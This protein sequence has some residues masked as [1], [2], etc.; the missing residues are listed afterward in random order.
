MDIEN[1]HKSNLNS[2][3]NF[4][5]EGKITLRVC[6]FNK[7]DTYN[8]EVSPEAF[9]E[10]I[11]EINKS[12]IEI[13]I[14]V[15][16]DHANYIIS[17]NINNLYKKEDGLYAEFKIDEEIK[18]S[19]PTF[20]Q[21]IIDLYNNQKL[22]A[23]MGAKNLDSTLKPNRFEKK[24]N[25]EYDLLKKLKLYHI[26]L[27]EDPIDKTAEVL[28]FKSFLTI[29]KYP[30]YLSETWDVNDANRKWREY[31]NSNEKPSD[32]YKNA[33]LY[34]ENDKKDL[35]GSYHFQIVD[36]I[37]GE[38]VINSRAI[39]SIRGYLAGARFGIKILNEAEKNKLANT[40]VILYRKM[41]VVREQQGLEPLEYDDIIVK[42]Q[43]INE[44]INIEIDGRISATNFLKEN[45]EN[46]S[47]TNI[48]NFVDRIFNL[49]ANK[50][51]KAHGEE[52]TVNKSSTDKK[53]NLMSEL[54]K[55][56][57]KSYQSKSIK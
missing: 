52:P 55:E 46:F 16:W 25:L 36:I 15:N 54:A 53:S 18:K 49:T 1:I 26:A 42:S 40:L 56:L 9:D 3:F 21:N 10:Q 30:I 5:K 39:V 33:F 43:S 41:N 13:P 32:T 17:K 8:D 48:S 2:Y 38:P 51:I 7:I 50:E 6:S 27:T 22:F 23:S 45:I 12:N 28:I 14:Y 19:N 34:V 44:R 20:F 31:S 37:D 35:Y 29:P 57:A 47:N 24:K 11:D 4:D